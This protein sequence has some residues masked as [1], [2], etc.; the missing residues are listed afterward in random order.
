M[1]PIEVIVADVAKSALTGCAKSI[2]VE[3]AESVGGAQQLADQIAA[4]DA[5]KQCL[6]TLVQVRASADFGA[7][8]AKALRK[9]GRALGEFVGVRGVQGQLMR[10]YTEENT[11]PASVAAEL[12][13]L[14]R[15]NQEYMG[16]PQLP[17]GYWAQALAE[18]CAAV[19][20]VV[21]RRT[22]LQR[23][24]V[25]DPSRR[26]SVLPEALQ[27]LEQ[28]VAGDPDSPRPTK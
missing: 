5:V 14:W 15:T 17:T 10:P 28:Y 12:D 20:K 9:F 16:L 7:V 13:R 4:E 18:Y 2:V 27:M 21:S 22:L 6:S 3:L 23:A 25:S 1:N 24:R 11:D 8:S 19:A 26:L